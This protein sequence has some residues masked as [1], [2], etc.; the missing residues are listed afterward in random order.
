MTCQRCHDTGWVCEEH[1][2]KP[3]G[4][5]GCLDAGRAVPRL[6]SVEPRQGAAIAAGFRNRML[7]ISRRAAPSAGCAETRR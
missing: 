6:Q 5:D 3:M 4:H 1:H 7:A 2:D